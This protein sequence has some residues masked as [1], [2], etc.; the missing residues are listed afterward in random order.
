MGWATVARFPAGVGKG[1]FIFAITSKLAPGTTQ[2]HG[3][4]GLL[5]QGKSSRGVELTA[6][7]HLVPGL[8][9]RGAIPPLIHTSSWHSTHLV[10]HK[11]NFMILRNEFNKKVF[12]K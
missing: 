3:Y 10:K 1:C 2:P 12:L 7:L 4:L 6:H 9:M 5:R 8:R 11:A